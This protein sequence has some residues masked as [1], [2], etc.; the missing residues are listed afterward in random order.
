MFSW[1]VQL[2]QID[3]GKSSERDKPTG[4]TFTSSLTQRRSLHQS[5]LRLCCHSVSCEPNRKPSAMQSVC[6]IFAALGGS[7]RKHASAQKCSKSY[8]KPELI[9]AREK[10]SR[11]F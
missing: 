4:C 2:F 10:N 8:F 7:V 11:K 5:G 1:R 6:Q 3:R 9:S